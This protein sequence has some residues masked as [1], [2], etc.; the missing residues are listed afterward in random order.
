MS[1]TGKDD[2]DCVVVLKQYDEHPVF[3]VRKL[4]CLRHMFAF[5]GLLIWCDQSRQQLHLAFF[6]FSDESSQHAHLT[7]VLTL[8]NSFYNNSLIKNPLDER[9]VSL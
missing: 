5:S 8:K 7:Q 6:P 1:T 2:P 3:C 9:M 4:C